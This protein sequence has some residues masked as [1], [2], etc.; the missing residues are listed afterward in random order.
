MRFREYPSGFRALALLD[1]AYAIAALGS[2]IYLSVE[3]VPLT[4]EDGFIIGSSWRAVITIAFVLVFW[5]YRIR[6]AGGGR[7]TSVSLLLLAIIML[8][9]IP[10]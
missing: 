10:V 6:T 3:D 1:L 7:R 9:A 5:R 2:S 8:W 4:P